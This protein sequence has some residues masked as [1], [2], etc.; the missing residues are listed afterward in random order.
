[1]DVVVCCVSIL[2]SCVALSTVARAD[3]VRHL[4]VF[5]MSSLED[6][7]TIRRFGHFTLMLHLHSAVL[8]SNA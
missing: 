8:H 6:A 1:M 4:N 3:A 2:S 5:Y 7:T